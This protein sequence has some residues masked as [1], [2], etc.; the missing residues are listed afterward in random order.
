[1][2][3][4][5]AFVTITLFCACNG[6]FKPLPAFDLDSAN[7][8]WLMDTTNMKTCPIEITDASLSGGGANKSIHVSYH[9][10]TAYRISYIE[11]SWYCHDAKGLPA[12]NGRSG[13]SGGLDQRGLDSSQYANASFPSGGTTVVKLIKVW[14]SEVE[15]EGGERW[16][17][18]KQ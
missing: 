15:F 13:I 18:R 4:F 17:A 8:R 7:R 5:I 16:T 2:K 14:P 6:L 3:L 12:D 11:F 9:N 10:L 1:M